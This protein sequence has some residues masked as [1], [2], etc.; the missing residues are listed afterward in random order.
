[1]TPA[2]PSVTFPSSF[3]LVSGFRPLSNGHVLVGDPLGQALVELDLT[4]GTA[5]TIGHVGS[6]PQE[7]Q[8][9]DGLF[10]MGGDTT[11]L[12]DLGNARLT[13]VHPDGTFGETMPIV[14]AGGGGQ[15][16]M[17]IVLPRGRDHQGRLYYQPLGFG[18]PGGGLPDSGVVARFDPVSETIDTVG[19]VKLGESRQQRSGDNFAITPVPLS[20]EDNW[21][22]GRD[23]RVA[24][25]R[26]DGYYV[27]WVDPDG[28]VT[29]GPPV[30]Y[31]PV[32]VTTAEKQAWVDNAGVGGL[33]IQVSIGGGGTGSA[34]LGRGGSRGNRT[35][36]QYEEWPE[37]LPPFVENRMIV[38][39]SGE[40][41]VMRSAAAGGN[42]RYDVFDDGGNY[43]RAF[44]V[45]PR[46]RVVGFGPS[47]IYMVYRDDLDLE[48]VE[49][50]SAP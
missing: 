38:S 41:W 46:R 39:P 45:G 30:E 23:G 25:A 22:A 24:F 44:V 5:D 11:L 43:V 49:A 4:A 7:Y 2:E 13:V 6:G 9:P 32:P 21:A 10:A 12:L 15:I 37:V 16:A 36:D 27:E 50:Y 28:T 19:M 8:Q 48:Y 26:S 20:P 33:S 47:L 17:N 1:M 29:R 18:R 3:G 40:A 42:T 14:R 31:R 34:I 35:I